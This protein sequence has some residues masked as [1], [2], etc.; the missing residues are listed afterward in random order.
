MTKI[1]TTLPP[2]AIEPRIKLV[3]VFNTNESKA[4]TELTLNSD[5][6]CS[7]SNVK[8][9]SAFANLDLPRRDTKSKSMP[10][11]TGCKCP[12]VIVAD[13]DAFQHLYY[14]IMF[15]KASKSEE[16]SPRSK[17]LC[18][19]TC[20]SGEELLVKLNKVQECGCEGTRLVIIDYQMG[21]KKL[22]GVDTCI[23]VRKG[24]YKGPVLLRTSE[25]RDSLK[26]IHQDFEQLLE[27]NIIN[28]LINKSDTSFGE[29]IIQ[30]MRAEE[31]RSL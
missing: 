8:T 21:E 12:Q 24:G 27:G 11:Q 7:N 31:N 22:N 19:R 2:V 13:D 9:F 30:K 26:K 29:N 18:L 15:Q 14:K 1:A 5:S 25:T 10:A 3:P 17:D 6:Q 4:F 28:A 23:K 20:F 16:V